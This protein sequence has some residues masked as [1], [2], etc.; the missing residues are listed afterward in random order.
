MTALANEAEWR[1]SLRDGRIETSFDSYGSSE[2][3][4]LDLRIEVFDHVRVA[5]IRTRPDSFNR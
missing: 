3:E 2:L 1:E 4:A 5:L